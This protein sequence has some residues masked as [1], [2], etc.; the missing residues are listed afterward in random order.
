[1]E[2][3]YKYHTCSN[4]PKEGVRIVYDNHYAEREE[5]VWCLIIQRNATEDH[6]NENH[7]LEEVGETVWY[8]QLEITHCPYCGEKLFDPSEHYL[9]DYGQFM[10]IDATGWH[11][12]RM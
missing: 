9:E 1:M 2:T 5:Y 8:T 7:Y 6:L 11:R 12:R 3:K 10:H 4:L